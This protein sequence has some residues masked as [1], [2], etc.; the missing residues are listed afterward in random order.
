MEKISCAPKLLKLN[1]QYLV[2]KFVIVHLNIININN[3]IY[4]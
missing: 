4:N 1:L 3:H 2:N